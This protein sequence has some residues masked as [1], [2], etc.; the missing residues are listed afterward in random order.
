MA[1]GFIYM[2]FEYLSMDLKKVLDK[3]KSCIHPALVKSYLH[4]LL[5]ALSYCHMNRILH[6]DLKPQ[7][8]LVD[9]KGH[10]KLAVNTKKSKLK[11]HY[12]KIVIAFF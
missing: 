10:I 8:L 5:D 12:S 1:D 11:Q 2:V 4:Q 7:N 3:K 6:R 9:F